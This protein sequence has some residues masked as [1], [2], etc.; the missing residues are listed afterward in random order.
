MIY[1]RHFFCVTHFLTEKTS[2]LGD[3]A[4]LRPLIRS[5]FQANF[6]EHSYLEDY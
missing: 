2:T 4:N 3:A 5:I 1:L 6:S